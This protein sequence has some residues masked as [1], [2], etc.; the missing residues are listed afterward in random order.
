MP[1]ESRSWWEETR[2]AAG[3]RK[4]SGSGHRIYEGCPTRF[5]VGWVG[6]TRRVLASMETKEIFGGRKEPSSPTSGSSPAP[7]TRREREPSS[8]AT[9]HDLHPASRAEWVTGI[10]LAP[11]AWKVVVLR[12]QAGIEASRCAHG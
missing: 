7:V 1:R 10:E 5:G 3:R 12:L 8:V 11:P 4:G 2:A 9:R 6:P